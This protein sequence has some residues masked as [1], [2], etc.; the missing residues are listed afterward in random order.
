M[1]TCNQ[2]YRVS[3]HVTSS[4]VRGHTFQHSGSGARVL[5]EL[6]ASLGYTIRPYL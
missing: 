5:T 6:K 4:W 2:K 3:V 1:C